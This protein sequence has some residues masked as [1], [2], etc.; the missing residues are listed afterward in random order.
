METMSKSLTTGE[1]AAAVGIT[2]AT[3]QAWIAKKWIDPPAV[4]LV[5][6]RAVRFW[7]S[8]DIARLRAAKKKL[9]GVRTG[10]PKKK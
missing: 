5:R 7:N 3:L 1:A 8:K 6:H 10:R 9:Y 4:Q 2:R